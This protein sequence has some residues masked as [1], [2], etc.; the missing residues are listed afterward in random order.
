MKKA[1]KKTTMYLMI[2]MMSV[3][4]LGA[5]SDDDDD[6]PATSTGATGSGATTSTPTSGQKVAAY[7]AYS[8]KLDDGRPVWRWDSPL[9]RMKDLPAQFTLDIPGCYNN[10]QA[11]NNGVRYETS[12]IVIKQSDG[13]PGISVIAPS[14]CKSTQ[15]SV[16]T[17][18]KK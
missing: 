10:I 6:T 1:I 16:I 8:G 3:A 11:A 15:Q 7:G 18:V 4:L 13:H 9:L 14:S 12:G 2:G 17:Y 5:C